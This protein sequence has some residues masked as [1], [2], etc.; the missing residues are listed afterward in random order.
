MSRTA[1]GVTAVKECRFP[2]LFGYKTDVPHG[3]VTTLSTASFANLTALERKSSVTPY[4][5]QN[6]KLSEECYNF[7]G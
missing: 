3:A 7:S 1:H 5:P 2:P 6:I 4:F